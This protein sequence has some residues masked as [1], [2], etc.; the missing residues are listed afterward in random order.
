M[1]YKEEKN[2]ILSKPFYRNRLKAAILEMDDMDPVTLF[3]SFSHRG[4][5]NCE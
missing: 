5:G 1:T 3:M 4:I 2:H